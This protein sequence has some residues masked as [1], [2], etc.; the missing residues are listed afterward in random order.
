MIVM[1]GN[2]MTNSS[3]FGVATLEYA[4]N[5]DK[6]SIAKVEVGYAK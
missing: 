3:H 2:S 5:N 4:D 1:F 6:F